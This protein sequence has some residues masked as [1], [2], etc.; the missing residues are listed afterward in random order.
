M[1]TA[2]LC[3]V[4]IPVYNGA[5][6]I[7]RCLNALAVQSAPA[8]SFE[9]IVVDDGSRDETAQVVQRWRTAHPA[10]DL[11]LVQQVNAGPAAARNHGARVANTPL[12]LFTDADCAPRPHWVA[13]LCAPFDVNAPMQAANT[14]AGAKG[15]YATEQRQLTPRF[16]QA[17]YADR[18]DRMMGLAHIDFVDT[19]SAAYRRDVFLASGGFDATFPRPAWRIRSSAFG[20]CSRVQAGFRPLPW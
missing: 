17:E 7:E 16:V 2:A 14:V 8:A 5:Q 9:L 20:W 15:V 4:I 1:S 10:M 19:Y 11:R 3:S 13:A 6:T 12:L 18:Y